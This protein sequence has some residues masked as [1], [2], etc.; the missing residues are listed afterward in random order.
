MVVIAF[1]S[2]ESLSAAKLRIVTPL[3]VSSSCVYFH[4]LNTPSLVNLLSVPTQARQNEGM[5]SFRGCTVYTYAYLAISFCAKYLSMSSNKVTVN[6]SALTCPLTADGRT[7]PT[8]LFVCGSYSTDL[9]IR[10][11][12]LETVTNNGALCFFRCIISSSKRK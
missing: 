2:R 1:S 8:H 6:A 10:V 4:V 9:I 7:N 5:P 3:L 12:S 11:A